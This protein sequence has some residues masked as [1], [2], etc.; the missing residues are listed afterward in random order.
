MDI[1]FRNYN[2][3]LFGNQKNFVK[4]YIYTYIIFQLLLYSFA[5]G[6]ATLNLFQFLHTFI[7]MK[8]NQ[9]KNKKYNDNDNDN[10]NGKTLT[11]QVV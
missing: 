11:K 8:K 5:N 4:Y 2:Y 6:P 9:K 1:L 3:N 7:T 10:D